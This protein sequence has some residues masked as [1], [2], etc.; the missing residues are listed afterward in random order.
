V[1]IKALLVAVTVLWCS[2]VV[3]GS[4]DSGQVEL[5]RDDFSRFAPG[6]LS[7]PIGQLNGAVQ[8][9]HYIEHGGVATHPWRNPIVHLGGGR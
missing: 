4:D 3:P 2:A 7:T 9:Y 8:E 5:F 1:R 6:L